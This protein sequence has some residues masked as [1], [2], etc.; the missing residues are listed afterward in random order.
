MA[1]KTNKCCCTCDGC[2]I[3]SGG[4]CCQC[5]PE[6]IC[7][8]AQ[9]GDAYCNCEDVTV[10]ISWDD[11]SRSYAGFVCGID[12]RLYFKEVYGEC[13][14]CLESYC[15]GLTGDDAL[16]EAVDCSY[17][18][19]MEL[20]FDIDASDCGD[21]ECTDVT[22]TVTPEKLIEVSFCSGCPCV[23][24]CICFY[25]DVFDGNAMQGQPICSAT[26]VV[27]SDDDGRYEP[28][29]WNWTSD[30][31]EEC[32]LPG[33]IDVELCLVADET[34]QC[35]LKL[36]GT[37]ADTDVETAYEC[38]GGDPPESPSNDPRP[39]LVPGG[40]PCPDGFGYSA[41]FVTD[42]GNAV[43]ITAFPARCRECTHQCCCGI[44]AD[45]IFATITNAAGCWTNKWSPKQCC[46]CADGLVVV[47]D[48]VSQCTGP[49]VSSWIGSAEFC[50]STIELELICRTGDNDPTNWDLNFSLGG[51]PP[52]N[53][54]L[55]FNPEEASTCDPFHLVFTDIF[56]TARC[57]DIPPPTPPPPAD[58]PS[59]IDINITE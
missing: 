19:N 54:A 24:E 2:F 9:S 11:E 13:M 38:G 35:S 42:E 20:T 4:E 37:V 25:M 8:R 5:I 26:S 7:V 32:D 58:A 21:E 53:F 48:K 40:E 23:P 34:G 27:C 28:I 39:V 57:C 15:A 46:N 43:W 33:S 45:Q 1:L 56:F 18:P 31:P 44:N 17:L 59:F 55:V 14:L 3:W 16:C 52:C 49:N 50:S 36:T 22:L 6:R 41:C 30:W 47:M 29:C 12:V 10:S 51:A